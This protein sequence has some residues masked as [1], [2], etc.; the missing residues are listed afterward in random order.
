MFRRLILPP[1]LGSL[2]KT[3]HWHPI[4]H[5]SEW[6]RR[7]F[8]IHKLAQLHR[9][10]VISTDTLLERHTSNSEDTIKT[11]H[12]KS[13]TDMWIRFNW[14]R[15][16][17]NGTD[18]FKSRVTATTD[19]PGQWQNAFLFSETSRPALWPTQPPIQ[20]TPDFLRGVRTAGAWSW[21]L[22]SNYCRG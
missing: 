2:W 21:P 1:S 17:L 10:D 13:Y 9:A 5:F 7:L 11:D 20:R 18:R 4:I 8:Q 15:T 16:G 22:T 12:T 3:G 6:I 14:A 19:W